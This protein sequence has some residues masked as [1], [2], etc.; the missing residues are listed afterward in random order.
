MEHIEIDHVEVSD[1]NIE[2]S[3]WVSGYRQLQQVTFKTRDFENWLAN[4]RDISVNVY[5]DHWDAYVP[6]EAAAP[7]E[8]SASRATT[9]EPSASRAAPSEPAASRARQSGLGSMILYQDMKRYLSYRFG[10]LK[11]V[12]DAPASQY[13]Y[14]KPM[15]KVSRVKKGK[16][17]SESA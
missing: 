4:G 13:A 16:A 1:L 12:S 9:S 15:T 2:V 7:S 14:K 3:Y 8:P 5:W 10:M 6:D 17:G 11:P